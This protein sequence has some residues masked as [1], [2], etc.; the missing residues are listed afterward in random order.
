MRPKGV[1]QSIRP[2]DQQQAVHQ[3][4]AERQFFRLLHAIQAIK[5]DMRYGQADFGNVIGLNDRKA[6]AGRF[7]CQ[8]KTGEDST[9]QRRLA[10]AQATF[11]RDD[12]ADTRFPR[13]TLA[14]GQHGLFPG[15]KQFRVSHA[16]IR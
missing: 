11:Q 16:A 3:I 9:R 5:I 1:A 8:A 10:S 14:K 15:Q 6:G 13:D 12:I 2:F 4:I 7:S